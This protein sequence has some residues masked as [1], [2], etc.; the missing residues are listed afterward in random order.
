MA[1]CAVTIEHAMKQNA[2]I[3][4]YEDYF[5]GTYADHSME[6]PNYKSIA[7]FKCAR[8]APPPPPPATLSP[9]PR[10]P[11]SRLLPPPPLTRWARRRDPSPFKRCATSVCWYPDQVRR[12][13]RIVPT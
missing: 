12:Q 8:P 5:T 6:Q 2:A 13:D 1:A 7:V 9:P 10:R 3:D 11:P 4:I